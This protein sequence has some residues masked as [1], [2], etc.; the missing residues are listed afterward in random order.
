[1]PAERCVWITGASTGLGRAIALRFAAAGH[2]VA[3]SARGLEQL[4][5]LAAEAN[6][7]VSAKPLDVTDRG[8]TAAT[9]AE[10]E[11]EN[12]PIDIAILNA[13]THLPMA[14]DKYNADTVAK[15]LDVNVMG[16]AYGLEA[17][18]PRM[19]ARRAGTVAVVSSVAG[20]R[21]L[22]TAAAYGASKAA[23][24]NMCES[25]KLELDR[26]GVR[27]V[28]INPGFIDTPLTA[29]NPFPMPFLMPADKAAERVYRGLIDGRGF[30]ITFPRRFTWMLKFL[31]ML[32][33]RLY[34]AATRKTVP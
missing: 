25:L 28:L 11:E 8:A 16:V 19:I 3:A 13:G 24:I 31:R 21:G 2:H 26:Y 10:I 14:A 30:E 4:Q 1:M 29:K 12:G 18:L 5:S 34:F 7:P 27:L 22:P 32:P 15:L 33:Y 20:Y 9:I 23:L 17:L 6:G